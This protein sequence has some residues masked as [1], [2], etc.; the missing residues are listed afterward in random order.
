MLN[1]AHIVGLLLP[2]ISVSICPADAM[3]GDWKYS[4]SSDRMDNSIFRFAS[5]DSTDVVQANFP[6]KNH[7]PELTVRTKNG[8]DLNVLLEFSGQAQ[9][10]DIYGGSLRVKFDS[11][12]PVVWS[13]G[14]P[15]DGGKTGL[16]FI[17]NEQSFL[18]RL[19][20][21]KT[22]MIELPYYSEG[23][24]T[25]SFDVTGLDVTQLGFKG[26]TQSKKGA[27]N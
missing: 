25:F 4:S 16:V 18:S 7:R 27:A 21:A 11:G 17:R 15:A 12:A 24:K 2:I 19:R 8:R 3:A 26:P 20:K 10:S 13:F 23:R 5:L 14:M 6:Y 9:R 1:A 22:V